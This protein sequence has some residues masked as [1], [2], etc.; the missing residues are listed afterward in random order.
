M[1]DRVKV[2]KEFSGLDIKASNF[3]FDGK[4]QFWPESTIPGGWVGGWTDKL[5]IE[6]AQPSW[7]L[8]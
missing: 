6:P 3:A 8:S 2:W 7:G 1:T 5:G 4:V